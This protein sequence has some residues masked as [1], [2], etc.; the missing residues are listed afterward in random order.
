MMQRFG[1]F[2][3]YTFFLRRGRNIRCHWSAYSDRKSELEGGNILSK[4]VEVINSSLGRFSYLNFGTVVSNCDIGR[5]TCVGPEVIIGGL[6]QHPRSRRSIHRMFYSKSKDIWHEY[7]SSENFSESERVRIGNDVW[8]GARAIILDGV[9][10]GDGAIVA[11][12][13]VVAKDV[14]PYSIV[15]GVP[16]NLIRKRFSVE[17]S[18]ALSREAWWNFS[19]TQLKR[20]VA[21]GDFSEELE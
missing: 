17:M 18:G 16:A 10:I 1:W 13:A 8:I 19:D 21:A 14:E 9:T 7:C 11:A 2:F 6:G 20:A 15:G 3:K 5:F 12:G 4:R